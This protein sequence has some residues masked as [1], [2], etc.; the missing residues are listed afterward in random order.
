MVYDDAEKL[1]AEVKESGE[2]L[3]DEA[4]SILFPDSF[5]LGL[6]KYKYSRNSYTKIIGYNTTFFPRW[7]IIKIPLQSV[8][9][10]LKAQIMQ[11]SDDGKEGYAV[12][13]NN[14]ESQVGQLKSPSSALHA[15][16][17]P[18]SGTSTLIVSSF[19]FF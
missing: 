16:L 13:Y 19:S 1:Y 12:M 15:Q 18:A 5:P 3:L 11:A 4:L 10:A 17:L 6:A 9:S 14:G 2:S 7:D 8:N